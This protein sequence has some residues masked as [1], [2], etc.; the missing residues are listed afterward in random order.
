MSRQRARLG[1]Q[2]GAIVLVILLALRLALD[3]LNLACRLAAWLLLRACWALEWAVDRLSIRATLRPSGVIKREIIKSVAAPAYQPVVHARP[4][5][6]RPQIAP[7]PVAQT[8]SDDVAKLCRLLG[9]NDP[10]TRRMAEAMLASSTRV[11]VY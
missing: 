8:Q 6:P 1:T 5:L 10:E 9:R 11:R 3:V 2:T 7:Q 4:T